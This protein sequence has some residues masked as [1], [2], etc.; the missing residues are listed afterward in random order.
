MIQTVLVEGLGVI[1]DG[2]GRL[3][4]ASPAV[5]LHRLLA[6]ILQV[7]L[8]HQGIGDRSLHDQVGPDCST[9]VL[10]ITDLMGIIITITDYTVVLDHHLTLTILEGIDRAILNNQ[11]GKKEGTD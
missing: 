9:L 6:A 5:D 1:E 11:D 7:N 3:Q 4:E 10:H 8:L 2:A